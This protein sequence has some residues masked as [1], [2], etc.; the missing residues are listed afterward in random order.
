MLL[1][2]MLRDC[3]IISDTVP[4][5]RVTVVRMSAAARRRSYVKTS[6][7][8]FKSYGITEEQ[9][10]CSMGK[11]RPGEG[12]GFHEWMC[13]FSRREGREIFR[14]ASANGRRGSVLHGNNGWDREGYI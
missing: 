8:V 2:K 12:Y 1:L 4:K 9:K 6:T 7:S 10:D 14:R 13:S 11:G 3:R 5:Y